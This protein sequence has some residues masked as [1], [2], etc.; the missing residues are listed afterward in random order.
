MKRDF[1]FSC[2]LPVHDVCGET[3]E[4]EGSGKT[5]QIVEVAPGG[6]ED[7]LKFPK[8]AHNSSE[9]EKRVAINS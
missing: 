6:F 2:F 5:A 4:G 1:I 8:M 7:Y 9:K 3:S